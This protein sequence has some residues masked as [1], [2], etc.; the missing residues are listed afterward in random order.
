[1]ARE[2]PN[3]IAR[4]TNLSTT[5]IITRTDAMANNLASVMP[6]IVDLTGS[7]TEAASIF[8]SLERLGTDPSIL[9]YEITSVVRGPRHG[10]VSTSAWRVRA[11][12]GVRQTEPQSDV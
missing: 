2:A 12:R 3:P 8:R 7:E 6:Q 10:G 9:F 11:D 1:M 5:F 4:R